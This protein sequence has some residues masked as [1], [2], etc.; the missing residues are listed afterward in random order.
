MSL[1]RAE[2][3]QSGSSCDKWEININYLYT[4]L[5]SSLRKCFTALMASLRPK[6]S[7]K[8]NSYKY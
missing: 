8:I 3:K 6:V 4:F 7:E 5:N 2:N 1:L